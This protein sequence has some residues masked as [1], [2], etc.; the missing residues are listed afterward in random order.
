MTTQ[1]HIEDL[2]REVR[3]LSVKLAALKAE[4]DEKPAHEVMDKLSKDGAKY[5]AGGLTGSFAWGE[6]PQG[7]DFWQAVWD[8]LCAISRGDDCTEL[9]MPVAKWVK[10]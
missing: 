9:P 8:H 1:A 2:Q 7:N 4:I 5:V 10:S 3:E 6:S